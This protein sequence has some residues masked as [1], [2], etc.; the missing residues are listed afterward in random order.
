MDLIMV[1]GLRI[2]DSVLFFTSVYKINFSQCV[3]CHYDK[4]FKNEGEC[5]Y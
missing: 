2:N 4:T 1:V 5:N 3:N